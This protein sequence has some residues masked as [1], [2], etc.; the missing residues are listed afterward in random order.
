[1]DYAR[2]AEA[3]RAEAL[4]QL[5]KPE[6]PFLLRLARAFDELERRGPGR[7]VLLAGSEQDA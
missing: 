5:G 2:E 6:A 1:M 4:R 7:K 3:C